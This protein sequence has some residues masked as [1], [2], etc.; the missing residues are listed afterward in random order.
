MSLDKAI[1]YV[2]NNTLYD[3]DY[4]YDIEDNLVWS[5]ANDRKAS[6]DLLNILQGEKDD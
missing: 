5:G 3:E 4:D 6:N 1:E 2:E